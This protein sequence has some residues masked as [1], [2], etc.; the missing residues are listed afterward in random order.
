M[1]TNN[2][3]NRLLE[4]LVDRALFELSEQEQLELDSLLETNSDFDSDCMDRIASMLMMTTVHEQ[5]R[6][7]PVELSRRVASGMAPF[8]VDPKTPSRDITETTR[9]VEP[10]T[11]GQNGWSTLAMM[12]GW[13]AAA[14]LLVAFILPEFLPRQQPSPPSMAQ[15]LQELINES[16]ESLIQR[17]WTR[18]EDAAAANASGSIVWDNKK[19]EGYMTFSGLPSQKGGNGYQLWIFDANGDERYPVDGGF[20]NIPEGQPE[21]IIPIDAKIP[22]Q[23]PTSFAITIEDHPVVVSNRVRLPLLAPPPETESEQP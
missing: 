2:D 3:E 23:E 12:S 22:V 6:E 19:Q 16:D 1:I 11:E 14:A 13:I 15:L 4:L 18:T 7:I 10:R 8:I 21:V 20:F 17:E 9:R 5:T